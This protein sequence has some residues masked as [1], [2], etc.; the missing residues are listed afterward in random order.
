M[1]IDGYVRNWPIPLYQIS[2]LCESPEIILDLVIGMSKLKKLLLDLNGNFK[3]SNWSSVLTGS[4]I[5]FFTHKIIATR[6]GALVSWNS[7]ILLTCLIS[8]VCPVSMIDFVGWFPLVFIVWHVWN[9]N[10]WLFVF[11][12]VSLAMN[13][14]DYM[15]DCPGEQGD[16]KSMQI[17]QVEFNTMASSFGGLAVVVSKYH[18]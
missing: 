3:Y 8:D 14:S 17:K 5:M 9:C 18:K 1:K 2:H 11:Q 12:P 4:S 10:I 6:M 16:T 7:L 13:R 15:L